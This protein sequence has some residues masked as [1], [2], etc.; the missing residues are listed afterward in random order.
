MQMHVLRTVSLCFYTL[1]QL[2]QIHRLVATSTFQA[3]EFAS[4]HTRLD[5]CNSLLVGLRLALCSD[6]SRFWMWWWRPCLRPASFRPY[7][8][9]SR[10][11]TL[12]ASPR[13]HPV[14]DCCF[15]IGVLRGSAPRYLET[16]TRIVDLPGWRVLRSASIHQS[17]GR[18]ICPAFDHR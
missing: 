13:A 1:R 9:R 8:R 17:P 7:H 14:Q 15:H 5:Y 11:F 2:R 10:L 16:P 12:V 18:S 4:M 6:Y 3:L